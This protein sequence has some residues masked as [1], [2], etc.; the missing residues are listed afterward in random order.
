MLNE[1]DVITKP[2]IFFWNI[3][4]I[5]KQTCEEKDKDGW[6]LV[7]LIQLQSGIHFIFKRKI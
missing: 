7:N 2:L 6:E 3:P 5:I 4:K 1:Y